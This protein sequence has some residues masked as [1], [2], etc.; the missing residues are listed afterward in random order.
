MIGYFS[1]NELVRIKVD[2][3]AQTVYYIR[4][5][6]GYLIGINLSEAS[7]M[8]IRLQDNDVK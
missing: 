6:D 3:N 2:G 7:G 5:E 8:L 1:N 4:E